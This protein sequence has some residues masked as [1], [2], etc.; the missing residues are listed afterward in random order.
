MCPSARPPRAVASTVAVETQLAGLESRF[1]LLKSQVRQAQQL[2]SLGTAAATIAHEVNNLLT[3]ILN[4]A[5]TALECGDEALQRK[6]L[7]VTLKNAQMLVAMSRRVLE[8]SA[9]KPAKRE[10][11]QV[12]AAAQD[13][14][15]SLCRDLSKDG[16]RFVVNI[17]ESETVWADVLQLQQLFFNLFLNARDVMAPEH[18][19]RLTVSATRSDKAVVIEVHNTGKVIPADLLDCIFDP[20]QSTKSAQSEG[21]NHCSGLGLALCRDIVEE[22]GGTIRVKSAPDTGTTFTITLPATQRDQE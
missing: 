6:A 18:S 12:R 7:T 9:A 15:A 11:I 17:D 5:K 14:A 16:I 1:V 19:G 13:A 4:Y 10:S 2:A 8:I 3:P 20:F 22:N 21:P